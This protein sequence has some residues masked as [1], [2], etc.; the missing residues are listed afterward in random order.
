MKHLPVEC[1]TES[2]SVN[3]PIKAV[4]FRNLKFIVNKYLGCK[5]SKQGKKNAGLFFFNT[6]SF[7]SSIKKK[8]NFFLPSL[9]VPPSSV[10]WYLL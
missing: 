9:K 1:A 6:H 10:G 5:H 3:N 7:V 2:I 4:T 8:I